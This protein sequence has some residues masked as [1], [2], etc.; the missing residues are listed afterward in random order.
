M[1]QKLLQAEA[2]RQNVSGYRLAKLTGLSMRAC[3]K[4]LAGV[5]DL[6]GENVSKVAAALGLGLRPVSKRPGAAAGKGEKA[7]PRA[8]AAK[9]WRPTKAKRIPKA[10]KAEKA[11]G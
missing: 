6:H 9:A 11:K 5:G 3:Q 8:P 4:Y 7:P 1:F 10:A 2:G